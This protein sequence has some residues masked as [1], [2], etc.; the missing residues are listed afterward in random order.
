MKFN[1]LN[2]F[3]NLIYSRRPEIPYSSGFAGFK[4]KSVTP[5]FD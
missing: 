1:L 2:P 3:V 4:F 5:R